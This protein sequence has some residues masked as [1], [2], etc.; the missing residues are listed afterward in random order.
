MIVLVTE[1]VRL[2]ET[3]H[4]APYLEQHNSLLSLL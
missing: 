2:L 1:I 4:E 3:R